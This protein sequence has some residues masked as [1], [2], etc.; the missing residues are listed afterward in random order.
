MVNCPV[1]GKNLKNEKF[2]PKC[3]SA[4]REASTGKN[5]PSNNHDEKYCV[6][7]GE[8]I[9]KDSQFCSSCGHDINYGLPRRIEVGTPKKSSSNK[10]RYALFFVIGI[11]A[12]IGLV[13]ALTMP[14]QHGNTTINNVD[15]NIPEGYIAD[16]QKANEFKSG[17]IQ[18]FPYDNY[19]EIQAY[20]NGNDDIFIAVINAPWGSN[21]DNVAGQS[22]S[23]N[24]HKGKLMDID[25]IQGFIYMRNG[26]IVAVAG[27]MDVIEKVIV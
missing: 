22:M 21:L 15:F 10:K 9:E 18:T 13:G 24:W 4:V 7:C 12:V 16:M 27:N 8:M 14:S 17:F 2:C 5:N 1:C 19:Y 20:S 11:I 3:G 25:G 26:K 23:I 6:N